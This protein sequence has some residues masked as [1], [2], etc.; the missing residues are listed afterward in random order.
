VFDCIGKQE[1]LKI[2]IV[3]LGRMGFSLAQQLDEEGH[4]LIVVDTDKE[5]IQQTTTVIDCLGIAESGFNLS[6]LEDQNMGNLDLLIAVTG[7]DEVNLITC[8]LAEKM[9]VPKRI[10]RIESSKLIEQLIENHDIDFI[11]PEAITVERLKVMC[12]QSGTTD[13]TDFASGSIL[14][15]AFLI[16]K[17]NV[18]AGKTLVELRQNS[19]IPFVVAMVRRGEDLFTATGDTIFMVSDTIYVFLNKE[20]LDQF[21]KDHNFRRCANRVIVFGASS[22]GVK[23]CSELENEIEDL[24]LIEPEQATVNQSSEHLL[25]TSIIHG[26]PFDKNLLEDLKCENTDYFIAISDNDEAN[27]AAA[28]MAKRLGALTT[29]TLTSQPEYV[30][31]FEPLPHLDAVVSPIFLSVGNV[32]KQVRGDKI[33]TLTM[34]AGRRGEAF[35]VEVAL[36]AS[37]EN[38]AVKEAGFPEGLILAAVIE[39]EQAFLP[40]GDT[41]LKAGMKIIAVAA[42]D[43]A[44]KSTK[45][46]GNEK[47]DRLSIF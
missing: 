39:D 45:L 12:T 46:F 44:I 34:F 31:I 20:N 7:S 6:H 17:G 14:M 26:S 11:N 37:V 1:I 33:L 47:K 8:L 15:K 43:V 41:V 23:L 21:I 9:N 32:I 4:E 5:K 22:L 16:T 27:L 36:G 19:S 10:A 29:V 18:F 25:S 30:E 42:R 2:V 13:S 28:L 38:K 35:E 3:G 24:I 40:D